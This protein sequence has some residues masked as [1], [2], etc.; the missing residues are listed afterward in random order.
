MNTTAHNKVNIRPGVSIL[1]ILP[2]LN[3]KPWFAIAEFIDN[4][5][6]SYIDY[7][8]D[9]NTTN[10]DNTIL[11]VEIKIDQSDGGRITIRDNAAGIHLLI[12]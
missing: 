10:G 5:I 4:S 7:R 8:D 11:R 9:I 3:Y 2:H 12:R 1:S 6:Q